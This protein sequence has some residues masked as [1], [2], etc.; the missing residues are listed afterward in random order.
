MAEAIEAVQSGKMGTL[1]AAKAFSVPRTT[2]QRLAKTSVSG[3]VKKQLSSRAPVF[4][5][6]MEAE[7]VNHIKN[8][9][10]RFFG[11]TT[12]ELRKVVYQYATLNGLK[13]PFNT[14][15][16]KAGKDWLRSFLMR[17]PE[18]VLRT[19][20]NTSA[21]RASGFNK[22]TVFKFFDLLQ[23]ETE[24]SKFPPSRI[25]NVD[26][27]GV[28]TVPNKPSKVLL[29]KGK[30]QVG[31]IASAERGQ[32]VTVELC[33]SATGH[34]IPP[35]FIFPRVRMKQEL[36]DH[37]PPGAVAVPHKS[38][39]MQSDIFVDWFKHFVAHQSYE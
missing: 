39:W 24:K 9:D 20:E 6:T 14:A 30:K 25:Y 13:H 18:I 35:L 29:F 37:A 8:M 36:L 3:G 17:H 21:A 31:V 33:M 4:S 23:A 26:E 10:S 11:F 15:N 34:Y 1:K 19:P 12:T 22:T 38:G 27:T 2:I 16:C 28:T 7:L 32:L 5:V